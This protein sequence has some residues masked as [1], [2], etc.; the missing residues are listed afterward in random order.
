[1]AAITTTLLTTLRT[2]LRGEFK[3]AF[4]NALA[5]ADWKKLATVISSAT[6][7]NTYDWLGK[8]PQMREWIGDRVVKDIAGFS[9]A[10]TNKKNEATLGVS[11]EDIEDDNIG[12]YKTLASSMGQEAS[13]F[14]SRELAKILIAGDKSL[15]YDGQNFFDTDHPVYPNADGTGDA[16]NVSN[17]QGSA[18]A[19]GA[20]WFLLCLNRP[21]K[22]FIVQERVRPEFDEVTDTHNDH[23]F[24]KDEYLYG[25]R[26]R[27]NFGYGLWQQAVFSR[28]TLNA[29]N[30]T[31]AY[32]TM[33]E[34]TR[35]GGDPIGFRPTHLVVPPSLRSAAEEIVNKANLAGGESNV[36]Y[37]K[38]ELIVLD[39]LD[40]RSVVATP[41]ASVAG[42]SYSGAQSV[43]LTCATSG[44]EI[45]YTTD[46][47]TPTA[48]SVKASGAI[49]IAATKT[50][51][52]VAVKDGLVDSAVFS[53][54]YT[55]S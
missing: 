28:E 54:T 26:H 50:L 52:A 35:D 42:G 11:R 16:K 55:I 23:V 48:K 46:G 30:F 12:Q 36:N 41:A 9:Y 47:T 2:T 20:P 25:I 15:C 32:Q 18:S 13:D 29:A 39:W 4:D 37:H 17:I 14:Y 33:C 34:F 53:A 21:L 27:G 3:I 6:K 24:M 38:V 44:A 1:M 51:K 8:F 40:G 5:N 31:G 43:T 7:S 45:H 22:P 19:L 49:S 10:I